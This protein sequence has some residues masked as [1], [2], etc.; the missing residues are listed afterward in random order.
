MFY[1]DKLDL[2]KEIKK[3]LVHL[4]KLSDKDKMFGE[5]NIISE[6]FRS[7]LAN[8]YQATVEKL[9]KLI[10]Q[11]ESKYSKIHIC[12]VEPVLLQECI[13]DESRIV[14]GIKEVM[15]RRHRQSLI[16]ADKTHETYTKLYYS[17]STSN[18]TCSFKCQK[19][20]FSHRVDI[21]TN[22]TVDEVCDIPTMN[23]FLVDILLWSGILVCFTTFCATMDYVPPIEIL[24]SL[25]VVIVGWFICRM[26]RE[27][28]KEDVYAGRVFRE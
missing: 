23:I 28:E 4:R 8:D 2:K 12:M 16:H 19:V 20:I 14:R 3:N 17:Y 26:I 5:K 7:P 9:G 15:G 25:P 10:K 18:F 11:Y 24:L 1:K 27:K 21:Q 6:I 22:P 13:F